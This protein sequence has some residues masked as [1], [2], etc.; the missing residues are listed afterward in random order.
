MNLSI[1]TDSVGAARKPTGD[2]SERILSP[3]RNL[4]N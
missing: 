3:V 1:E 2:I 4:R